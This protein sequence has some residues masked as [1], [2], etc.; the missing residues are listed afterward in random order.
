[1]NTTFVIIKP[2]ALERGL[3]G[4]IITRFEDMGLYIVRIEK[5]TKNKVWCRSH[6][7]DINIVEM[8][9]RLENCMCS[10]P[11]IG[12][13]LM[14]DCAIVRVRRMLGATDARMAVPGTIRG[15]FGRYSGPHNLVHASDSPEAVL[16]ETELFFDVD[17]DA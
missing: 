8:Y 3:L 6:Y 13:V 17:T 14:G 9:D 10:A 1:M 16:R 12:I 7:K 5:R 11:L 15:D 2:D 4:Q